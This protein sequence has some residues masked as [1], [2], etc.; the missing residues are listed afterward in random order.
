MKQIPVIILGAG[1][2]GQA[3]LQQIV[4]GRSRAAERN[5]IQF[6]VVA[7]A[8]RRSMTWEPQ[9]M[10]DLQIISVIE[11]KRLGLPANP[12]QLPLP[13]LPG[14][15]PSNLDIIDF[16]LAAGL[17]KAII[18]DVTAESGM[19][20]VYDRA[21][22][23]GYGIVMANKKALAGPWSSA[24]KY[25]NHLQIRHESTVGGGQPVIAT[26]RTLLDT[27]DPIRQI[28]GQLSGTLG[29]ICG[30]LDRGVPFSQAV[31]EAKAKGFTEPDPREDLGGQD[32]M[33]KVMILGRMS[34]W[35]LEAS[36]ITVE[37]LYPVELADLSVPKFMKA[38]AGLD[39]AMKERVDAAAAEG[40]V[41]R[42]VAEL[43]E[44][45]GTVGLKAISVASPLANLKYISFRTDRYD[46]EPLLIGGKGA[47][48]EMTAAGVL[49]D[50][51]DLV[52]E[53]R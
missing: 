53:T 23:K 37:S 25:F 3:L 45:Q 40:K 24:F 50:M 18:V 41:L 31:A 42:Y 19:E 33:R 29:F 13:H 28:E 9:G 16:A 39:E 5:R 1:G 38:V 4:D 36:D 44:G 14:E 10:T 15:R 22:E 43:Q 35:P 52:R 49:G 48:V 20:P 46:D 2:V 30:Q 34:G 27:H 6:N 47:G 12:G 17:E 11:A 26:L 32:V 8:D 7:V 21:L 51:I